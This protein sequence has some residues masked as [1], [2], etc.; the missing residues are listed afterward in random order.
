[1]SDDNKM[2]EH[3]LQDERRQRDR[4]SFSYLHNKSKNTSRI[5][6]NRQKGYFRH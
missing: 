1:M 4:K 6:R 5:D 3:F 2:L